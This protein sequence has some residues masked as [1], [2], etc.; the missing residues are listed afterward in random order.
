MSDE[1][2][3]KEVDIIFGFKYR[4][5]VMHEQRNNIDTCLMDKVSKLYA[6]SM[7]LAKLDLDITRQFSSSLSLDNVRDKYH[8]FSCCEYELCHEFIKICRKMDYSSKQVKII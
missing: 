2:L 3:S 6:R 1:F 7:K 4:D 5:D 8:I